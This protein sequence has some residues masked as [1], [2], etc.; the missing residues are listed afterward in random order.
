MAEISVHQVESAI[1]QALL[2]LLRG[3]TV[4]GKSL[5]GRVE[6]A[7]DLSQALSQRLF[8][9]DPLLFLTVLKIGSTPLPGGQA[10]VQLDLRLAICFRS[11]GVSAQD[12][13]SRAG[14]LSAAV[15]NA[16]EGSP[17]DLLGT[18]CDASKLLPA[19]EW[20]PYS[21]RTKCPSGWIC[22][23]LDLRVSSLIPSPAGL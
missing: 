1:V 16:I 15:V 6:A 11:Q 9:P 21:N 23:Q 4:S 17:P 20:G 8:G 18:T 7:I 3:T 19:L 10:V 13:A 5:A 2:D 12:D 14:R 22:R